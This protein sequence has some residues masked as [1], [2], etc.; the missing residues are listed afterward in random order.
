MWPLRSSLKV[1]TISSISSR[2]SDCR[3]AES[4]AIALATLK[5]ASQ[6]EVHAAVVPPFAPLREPPSSAFFS[7]L[8]TDGE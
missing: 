8:N 5:A 6:N 3:F 7:S 4:D 2:N 1:S